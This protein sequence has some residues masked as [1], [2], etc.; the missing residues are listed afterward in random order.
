MIRTW[1]HIS[2]LVLT[3]LVGHELAREQ[4]VE[5][6]VAYGTDPSQHLDLSVPS[7]T[8]FRTVVFVH[9][10]SLVG[11]DKGDA[12]YG[13]VCDAFPHAGIACATVNY[14]LAPAHAWPA[15]PEDVAAAAAWVRANIA[16]RGGDPAKVFLVG[17]SS[18]A[19]LVAL[20][21]TD[22][23]YLARHKLKPNDFAGVVP[24]GSIMWDDDLE[25]SLARNGRAK[26]EA[27][28]G[29]DPR[30]RIFGSLDTYLDQWPIRHVKAGLPPFLFLI[31]E[32]E[33]SNPP[34]LKT[35]GKF[36]VDARA[37]GNVADY[38]VLLGRTHYSAI[39][40][41]HLPGDAVFA[42]IRDFVMT[43]ASI[44]TRSRP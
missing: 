6:D 40:Q 5:R 16:S 36:I 21:A 1:Y 31:A 8:G 12:D 37:L 23:R 15:Q 20:V 18:G 38:K 10:G 22:E 28:W 3:V 39:R 42:V 34:L 11:G 29:T 4:R 7:T 27:G 26:V 43:H 24:M 41:L 19:M 33:Q 2:L 44:L 13:H 17:H 30:Q 14:R 9:G 32:T 25:Q 35:D